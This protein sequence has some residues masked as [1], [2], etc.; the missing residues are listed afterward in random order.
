[1]TVY[2]SAGV[3]LSVT[4]SNASG[5]CN[6]NELSVARKSHGCPLSLLRLIPWRQRTKGAPGPIALSDAHAVT[7]TM[8][9]M[10][11]QDTA[12]TASVCH[13][14]IRRIPF[15]RKL[16]VCLVPSPYLSA[17][18]RIRS[19]LALD[20]HSPRSRCLHHAS[21]VSHGYLLICPALFTR[22]SLRF[23]YTLRV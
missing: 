6:Q 23:D 21:L 11:E 2:R 14:G 7:F 3:L 19:C 15:S 10:C 17:T 20:T 5:K 12:Q 1:M 9:T 16:D 22:A 4:A 13:S 8:L 18:R